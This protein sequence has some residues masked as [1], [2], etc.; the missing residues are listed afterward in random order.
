MNEIANKFLLKV[1]KFMLEMYLIQPGFTCSAWGPFI[2]SK[3]RVQ[4]S[5]ETGD[6][7]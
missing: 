6:S 1:D 3:E 2:K 4:K 7:R 5:K